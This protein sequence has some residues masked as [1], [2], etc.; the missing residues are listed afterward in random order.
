MTEEN[1]HDNREAEETPLTEAQAGESAQVN[2][3]NL[4]CEC[5]RESA[6]EENSAE[7]ESQQVELSELDQ[8]LLRITELEDEVARRKA[9]LYN[10]QQEYSG[11]VKRAK[12]D[13]VNQQA[14]GVSKV[15]EALM[16]VLDNAD[17]ARQHGDLEGPAGAVV[18]ELEATLERNFG[19]KRFGEVGEAFDPE[20][21]EALMHQTS[22]DAETE[23]VAHLIQP[24]YRQGEKILRPARVGVVSPQ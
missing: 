14:F 5:E 3:E 9:D 19:L 24:G 4:G 8:A 10:L 6:G 15:L 17:L 7:E 13:A 22:E 21:H 20:V 1:L 18:S 11:Y 2:E 23:H 12:A 16:G